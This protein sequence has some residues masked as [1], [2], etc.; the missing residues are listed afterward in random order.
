MLEQV[1]KVYANLAGSLEAECLLSL[2]QIVLQG[3]A[4]WLHH[5]ERVTL[6]CIDR[7]ATFICVET[8]ALIIT[9]NELTATK[10][11]WKVISFAVVRLERLF[12]LLEDVIFF[13]VFLQI[14]TDFD[15]HVLHALLHV[16]R[17]IEFAVKAAREVSLDEVALREEQI[18][19]RIDL[20]LDSCN[21]CIFLLIY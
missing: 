17:P 20:A 8:I 3:L 11:C 21:L 16:L 12:Q 9:Y 1:H 6:C 4:Q 5:D 18:E 15:K 7:E 14:G 10:K 13:L 2:L 19:E